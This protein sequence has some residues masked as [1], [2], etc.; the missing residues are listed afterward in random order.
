MFIHRMFTTLIVA[1]TVLVILNRPIF[2]STM[3]L[4]GINY[5]GSDSSSIYSIYLTTLFVFTLAAYL[6]T[7]L[8]IGLSQNEL[9]ALG[10]L[11]LFFSSTSFGFYLT[12]QVHSYSRCF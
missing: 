11:V 3:G 10:L 12:P 4:L 9:V 6:Y 2:F 7:V 1:V 8:T 5:E